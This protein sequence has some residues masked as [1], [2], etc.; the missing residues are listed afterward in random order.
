MIDIEAATKEDNKLGNGSKR[1]CPS[2]SRCKCQTSVQ[3]FLV[4][5]WSFSLWKAGGW[6]FQIWKFLFYSVR[7]IMFPSIKLSSIYG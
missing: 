5:F 7:Q 4:I 1:R 6:Q 2:R 3:L